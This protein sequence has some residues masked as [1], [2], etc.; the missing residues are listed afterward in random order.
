MI[1]YGTSDNYNMT[2]Q[3][4]TSAPSYNVNNTAPNLASYD[5]VETI[6]S[7]S[8]I[9]TNGWV[10][11][12]SVASNS[13]N[14]QMYKGSTISFSSTYKM[15]FRFY[16]DKLSFS[17]GCSV[18]SFTIGGKGSP[19]CTASNKYISITYSY[20]STNNGNNVWPTWSAGSSYYLTISTTVSGYSNADYLFVTMT[21][22][23]QNAQYYVNNQN[24][25]GYCNCQTSGCCFS[26]CTYCSTCYNSFTDSYYSCNCYDDCCHSTICAYYTCTWYYGVDS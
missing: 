16:V 6:S 23:W 14:F 7:T 5:W 9:D 13:I 2:Q 15:T 21:Y 1:F 4:F 26:T 19:S 17:G 10:K 8:D 20:F 18:S 24:S 11:I 12:T 22:T 3:Y 25:C